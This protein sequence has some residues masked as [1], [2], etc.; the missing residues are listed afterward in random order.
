MQQRRIKVVIADD[1]RVYRD[2]LRL[3]LSKQKY[4]DVIGEASNWIDLIA[5]VKINS[6][7]VVLTDIKMPGMDG[8]EGVKTIH[9]NNQSAEIIALSMIDDEDLIDEILD[10][11]ALG[12]IT[13]SADNLEII[14][15]VDTVSKHQPYYC[16]VIAGI[17]DKENKRTKRT[18]LMSN[19]FFTD[20]ELTIISY[21]CQGYST[22]QMADKLF[23]NFKAIEWHR[24]NIYHKMNVQCVAG[25]VIFAVQNK[26]YKIS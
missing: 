8:I 4:I 24:N 16:S 11:G 13:K 22:K 9:Q 2:G 15:A 20:K 7:E 5:T 25:M 18:E 14:D 3:L 19:V 17:K 10:A 6:P 21:I 23:V 26:L 12:F 1:H